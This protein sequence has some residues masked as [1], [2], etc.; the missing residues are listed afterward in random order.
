MDR[1]CARRGTGTSSF[2]LK[3]VL[4]TAVPFAWIAPNIGRSEYA[5]LRYVTF[6]AP[7][8]QGVKHKAPINTSQH[9]MDREQTAFSFC[10]GVTV[11]TALLYL[12]LWLDYFNNYLS[13]ETTV[14]SVTPSH[15]CRSP[16]SSAEK[17][18]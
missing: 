8:S 7:L 4:G 12:S 6:R 2:P 18:S 5:L 13:I 17:L 11:V 14:T 1:Y 3:Q 9:P 16:P 15:Q 10:D